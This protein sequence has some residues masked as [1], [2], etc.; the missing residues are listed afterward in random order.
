MRARPFVSA[1]VEGPVDEAVVKR[2]IVHVGGAPGPVYGKQGKAALRD[3]V[4]DYNVAARRALW[5]ILVDLDGEEECAPTLRRTWIPEAAPHLCFRIA[6]RAVEAWLLADGERLATFLGIPSARVPTQ[7]EALRDPKQALV[8]LARASKRRE[9]RADMFPRP[10]SGRRVGP[11]Y[12][13]RVIEFIE[14]AWRP[15]VAAG[16]ADSLRRAIACLER[17]VDRA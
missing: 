8:G 10:G 5:V 15:K 9:I 6:V 3:R 17:M 13:S 4:R 12:T 7:P 2:L 1:A 14:S 11:A 16:Q